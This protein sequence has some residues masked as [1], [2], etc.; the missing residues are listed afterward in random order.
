[1]KPQ[2]RKSQLRGMA[3]EVTGTFMQL[4]H[5]SGLFLLIFGFALSGCGDDVKSTAEDACS[6]IPGDIVISEIMPDPMGDDKYLEWIE[7]YN[8]SASVEVLDRIRV[9]FVTTNDAGVVT[10]KEQ[11][12]DGAGAVSAQS[13]YVIGHG[14]VGVAPIDYSYFREDGNENISTLSQEASTI[15]IWCGDTLIDEASYGEGFAAPMPEEGKSIAFDGSVAPDALLNDDSK[16]WCEGTELYDGANYGTPGMRNAACGFA[17]CE[18][19]VAAREVVASQAG[20]LIITEVYADALGEEVTEEWIEVFVESSTGLDLNGLSLE[21]TTF[22][23]EGVPTV[24][25]AKIDATEC[26]PVEGGDYIVL[27]K[28]QDRDLNGDVDVDA[29]LDGLNLTNSKALTLR[30]LYF[31]VLVDEALVPVA[32]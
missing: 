6:L 27:G 28:S 10:V 25:V 22:N 13:Y 29:I 23:D 24:N 19:G 8:V 21:I 17:W 32:S 26:L 14:V 16:W 31:D 5:Y 2:S 1:M 20:N 12:L 9:E 15:R 4:S 3:P 7:L 18:E 11:Y 30:L